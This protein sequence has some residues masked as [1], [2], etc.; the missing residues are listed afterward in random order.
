VATSGRP[1]Q[2]E[3]LNS[4]AWLPDGSI[5]FNA[6]MLH[7]RMFGA[8]K[9]TAE[10]RIYGRLKSTVNLFGVDAEAV[11]ERLFGNSLLAREVLVKHSLFG[12]YR[13]FLAVGRD[14][15]FGALLSKG[16]AKASAI[17]LPRATLGAGSEGSLKV[18]TECVVEQ[19]RDAG[20]AVWHACHQIPF[21]QHCAKHW[22]T[23]VSKCRKCGAPLQTGHNTSL[24][25]EPCLHCGTITKSKRVDCL[26]GQASVA[27]QGAEL[28]SSMESH[29]RPVKWAALVDTAVEELGVWAAEGN[30]LSSDEVAGPL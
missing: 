17:Y 16:N 13:H 8:S 10:Q 12:F 25:G 20:Y 27:A 11:A 24:P 19:E 22:C 9:R 18:C 4:A 14:E 26:P 23:L 2:A 3:R 29:L 21:V 30:F 6:V 1:L 5:L 15:E 7:V 28:L